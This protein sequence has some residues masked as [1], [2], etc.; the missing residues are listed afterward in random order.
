MKFCLRSSVGY[1]RGGNFQEINFIESLF[2]IIYDLSVGF[3]LV[4]FAVEPKERIENTKA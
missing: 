2:T 3:E 4:A 1:E